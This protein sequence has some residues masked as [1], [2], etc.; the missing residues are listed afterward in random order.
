M[1]IS[2]T[3]DTPTASPLDR[4]VLAP[5]MRHKVDFAGPLAGYKSGVT[6]Q[7]GLKVLVT[8]PTKIIT[9]VKGEF[10]V[11]NAILNGLVRDKRK[12]IDAYVKH[13][14]E[15]LGLC[16]E[17]GKNDYGPVLDL[18]GPKNSGKSF[19]QQHI[20]TPLL[21]GRADDPYQYMKGEPPFNSSLTET[22]DLMLEDESA[23]K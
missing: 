16:I 10:P 15:G 3:R 12:S 11:I 20:L 22:G 7:N 19:F 18:A 14:Y 9:P 13:T 23:A 5:Q 1:G 2:K 4:T 8:K 6:E 21:G 17:T